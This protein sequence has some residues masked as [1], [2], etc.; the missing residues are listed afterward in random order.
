MAIVVLIMN[1]KYTI[2]KGIGRAR[3]SPRTETQARQGRFAIRDTIWQAREHSYLSL[4][5]T[6]SRVSLVRTGFGNTS[7]RA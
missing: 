3:P 4:S 2:Q 5:S 1:C 6:R 7:A